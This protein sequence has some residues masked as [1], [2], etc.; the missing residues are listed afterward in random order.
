MRE[1]IVDYTGVAAPLMFKQIDD[2]IIAVAASAYAQAPSE[3]VMWQ[4][5]WDWLAKG[6]DNTGAY[7]FGE[8]DSRVGYKA[9]FGV[10][11][12]IANP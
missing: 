5:Q 6:V 2:D 12:R 1:P 10:P 8:P 11:V 4:H 7:L 3:L 9:V